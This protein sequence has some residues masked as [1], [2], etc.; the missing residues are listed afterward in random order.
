MCGIS[1][2]FSND[3]LIGFHQ[4]FLAANNIVAYRGPDGE[5]I[6]LISPDQPRIRTFTKERPPDDADFAS[7]TL[8][9]GHRRLAIIDLSSSGSQPMT[10]ADQSLWIIFNGEIYNYI[11]LRRELRSK[12]RSF[13]TDSD[14]EVILYAFETW[15]EDCVHH[16]NGMWA[17][18]IADLHENRLFCSRDRMGVKPFHYY[19]DGSRFVFG[20]EIK[21]LLC[22]PFVPR[23]INERAAYEFLA[24][25]A[26]DYCE[27]TFF[28]GIFRLPQGHNLVLNMKE[29]SL[30]VRKYYQPSLEIDR[31][32]T[33]RKAAM[34][35]RE[36]L[37]DS[38]RLRLRS[39]VEVGSCLSGGLDSSSIVCL[40]HME[41]SAAGRGDI[42]RTFSSHFEEKEA[43][44]L[45]Y[46]EEVIRATGVQAHLICPTAGELMEDM[47]RLVWHQEEPFASTS[48]FSQWSVYK[49]VHRHG[50]KVMLDGQGA[51]EQLA[52]YVGL[53][54]SYFQEL[55]EKQERLRLGWEIF[56]DARLTGKPVLR[57]VPGKIGDFL[58]RYSGEKENRLSPP[59]A[60]WIH[61][62][63][64][65]RFQGQS[66]YLANQQVKPFG[67]REHLSNV[68][69][70]LT[71]LNN[72][73]SLLRY[74]DRNSMAFSVEAR[75]PFLDYRLVEFLLSLPSCLKIRNG[76]TKRVLRDGVAGVIPEKIRWRVGKLGFTTPERSWQRTILKPLILGA[77]RDDYMARFVVAEK[78][79]AFFRELEHIDL[80]DFSPWRWVNLYLWMKAF[81]LE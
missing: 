73:Q 53:I 45:E 11:E 19:F 23:R 9:F 63:L 30:S 5:G 22:F 80:L 79:L 16:F 44:E 51:D 33:C 8:G 78:A 24:F 60:D 32:M 35:F 38:V 76:Y 68:L 77:V 54:P 28:D 72:L 7:A 49:L 48:I 17:F 61:P 1:G 43:N 34:T 42:Q 69:Y 18:A 46:M 41:L 55:R 74:E 62:D 40:M 47:D 4:A 15:G 58:R 31:H 25:A 10:N 50:I 52:G 70:Q 21:Q 12:G 57:L 39:D 2:V 56:R 36:L 71:F 27:E 3:G 67:D 26:V 13:R 59:G 65:E 81:R 20:S 75:V 6:A 29:P 66:R 64:V 37:S 14:T